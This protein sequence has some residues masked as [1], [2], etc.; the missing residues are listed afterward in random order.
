MF[1]KPLPRGYRDRSGSKPKRDPGKVRTK[2]R[3][4]RRARARNRR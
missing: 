4:A 1:M 2:N 3:N